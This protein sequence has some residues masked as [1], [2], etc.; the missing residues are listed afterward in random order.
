MK[1][2][3]QKKHIKNKFTKNEKYSSYNTFY[4]FSESFLSFSMKKE[5]KILSI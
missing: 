5:K 1:K 2:F 3:N 4:Y